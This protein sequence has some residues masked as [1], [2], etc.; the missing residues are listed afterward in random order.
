MRRSVVTTNR[1]AFSSFKAEGYPTLWLAGLFSFISVQMQFLL[2][3]ILAW[4]LTEREG[5][6][7]LVYL[8]FGLAMLVSTPLGGVASDRLSK[9]AVLIGSQTAL[10]VVAVVMGF[11]VITGV[12][13]FWM[14]LIAG[15]VQGASFGFFG[16][17]R[18]AIAA[19]IVGRE[20]L[21]NAITLSL[22]SMNGTRVFAPALAGV[23]AGVAFIGIG[24]A[25]LIAAVCSSVSFIYLL[26]LPKPEAAASPPRLALSPQAVTA[27][28]ARTPEVE[29]ARPLA[30][31]AAGVRYV[32]ARPPL[33]RLV[34]S[35]FFVIMFGFNYVAFIPALIK[36]EY[37]LGDSWVGVIS[38]AGA[39]GAVLVSVPL[40]ARADSVWAK[41]M[42]TV[43]GLGFGLGVIGVGVSGSFWMAFGVIFFIGG[44]TTTYQSLSNTLAMA[45]TDDAHHGRVQS[46]MQLSFAGFGIAALPLGG[47]AEL[48]GLRPTIMIM[49]IVATA[50]ITVYGIFE[51][52]WPGL[53]PTHGPAS[54]SAERDAALPAAA[55]AGS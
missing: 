3:G 54:A 51:G 31:I 14:L 4:D 26:R 29:R 28:P 30:E 39:L 19:E 55:T 41:V 6:L 53:R 17:A 18:V 33:R 11:A 16:P 9:R 2:R 8:G 5:A 23:L 38:S 49:G 43:A 34:I 7:G 25:Y 24:G 13:Q 40:A 36:G 50:A 10:M 42:M 52:G 21:G 22:L 44:A 46:L 47:L 20:H 32:W 15:V 48:I 35:S 12:V 1:G 27:G 45:M 37:G